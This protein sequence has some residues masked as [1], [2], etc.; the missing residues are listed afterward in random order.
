MNPARE[1]VALPDRCS[2]IIAD[3]VVH[4]IGVCL[5]L[6]GAVTIVMMAV[7]IERINVAPILVYV[8]GLVTMLAFS[9]AYN[10]WP[11]SPVKWV[12]RRFDHSAIYLLIAATYTPFLGQMK[13]T[14]ASAGLGIGG[15][16]SAAAGVTH[17]M[18][19]ARLERYRCLHS[20]ASAIPS[21]SLWLLA[22]GGILY[23]FGTL[24]HL[25]E[26]L[27]FHNA[28]W[29]GF[30]L[31]AAS[32]HYSAVLACLPGH[33]RPFATRPKA[34]VK[35]LSADAMRR[36]EFIAARCGRAPKRLHCL[37]CLGVWGD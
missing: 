34:Y 13:N 9:A 4:A 16:L 11:V 29:H 8:I 14:L 25:W 17:S 6:I 30:V 2:E 33:K 10:M 19:A 35:K 27:R 31:L 21:P 22:V 23:S 18:P 5:G 36:R 3:G 26:R 15:W 24:F 12:L 37:V 28:T 32:C 20:L 7:K 1:F